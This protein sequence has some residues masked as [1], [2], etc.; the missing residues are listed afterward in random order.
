MALSTVIKIN[1]ISTT[2]LIVAAPQWTQSQ[3]VNAL[4]Y[5]AADIMVIPAR[6][7]VNYG[8]KL[9]DLVPPISV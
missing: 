8:R 1:S 3:V 5:G 9:K 7:V 6:V 2:P 4:R